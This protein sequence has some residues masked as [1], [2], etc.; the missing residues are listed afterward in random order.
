MSHPFRRCTLHKTHLEEF[1][2]F[3]RDEAHVAYRDGKGQF[4]VLQVQTPEN[5][6]QVVFSKNNMPEHYS[7]NSKLMPLVNLFYAWRKTK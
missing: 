7:V 4:Q 1:K 2:Q 6:W 5:G 3:L